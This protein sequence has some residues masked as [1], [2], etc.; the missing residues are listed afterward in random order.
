MDNNAVGTIQTLIAQKQAKLEE[1]QRAASYIPRVQADLAALERT[2]AIVKG[3]DVPSLTIAVRDS[4]RVEDHIQVSIPQL[5]YSILKET[6]TPLTGQQI[7]E[8]VAARGRKDEK[9][10]VL[11]GIYRNI[12]EGRLFKLVA[13]GTFGLLEWAA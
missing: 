4:S 13:P 11:G 6:G 12:K 7:M 1:L 5:V 2:L 3:E 9:A 10:S 8:R